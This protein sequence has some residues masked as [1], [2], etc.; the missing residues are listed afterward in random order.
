VSDGEC[1]GFIDGVSVG[2]IVGP[3]VPVAVGSTVTRG[4]AVGADVGTA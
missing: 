3:T 1:E 4:E 2:S